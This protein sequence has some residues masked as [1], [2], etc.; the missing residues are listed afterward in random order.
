MGGARRR[1]SKRK[2]H[3]GG[4]LVPGAPRK[5]SLK[6]RFPT[7]SRGSDGEE[8]GP[9][10]A[11]STSEPCAR[12][13]ILGSFDHDAIAHLRSLDVAFLVG[14]PDLNCGGGEVREAVSDDD[15]TKA[16]SE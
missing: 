15:A 13:R 4:G 11:P 5:K 14:C 10:S 3:D 1:M 9:S 6:R 2:K 16:G 7:T 8:G 12:R